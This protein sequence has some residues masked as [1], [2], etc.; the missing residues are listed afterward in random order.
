MASLQR[1]LNSLSNVKKTEKWFSKQVKIL[2][3]VEASS[4][5]VTTKDSFSKP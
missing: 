1:T 3:T 5:S 2:A 4:F